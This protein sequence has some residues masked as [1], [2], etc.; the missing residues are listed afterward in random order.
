MTFSTPWYALVGLAVLLPLAGAWQRL[1]ASAVL[2]EELAL[3]APP[4]AQRL[5]RPLAIAVLF[6][7]VAA[8]AAQPSLRTEQHRRAR[9]DA[10]VFIAVD[11]SRS[12]L[13]SSGVTGPPRYLRALRF[14]RRLHRTFPQVPAGIASL[15]N[16]VLPY[17]FPTT[18]DAALEQVLQHGYGIERPPPEVTSGS[19]ISTFDALDDVAQHDFFAKDVK[20]RVFVVLSDAETLPFHI[21][22]VLTDLERARVDTVVVRFWKPDERVYRLDGKLERY[23]PSAPRELDVLRARGWSAFDET[24]FGAVR[25]VVARAVGHGPVHTVALER[26]D[27][28]VG[29]YVAALALVPLLVLLWP[30]LALQRAARRPAQRSSAGPV[31]ARAAAPVSSGE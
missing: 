24:Q 15:T 3:P 20:K 4:L 16:R 27:R 22:Q 10:A 8:A 13:A 25:R 7:L 23:R 30:L 1:R 2:R 26:L 29:P 11:N 12:M 28:P 14:A 6:G 17:V 19:E 9:T 5:V 21:R 18:S 31:R